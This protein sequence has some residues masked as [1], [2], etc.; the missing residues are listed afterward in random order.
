MEKTFLELVKF[1]TKEIK[2]I[3][4]KNKESLIYFEK[5]IKNS[6]FY[7]EEMYNDSIN[8]EEDYYK[9]YDKCIF[10]LNSLYNS[11]LKDKEKIFYQILKIRNE[12][13][14][15][16]LKEE[17]NSD[18][19]RFYQDK[20]NEKKEIKDWYNFFSEFNGFIKDKLNMNIDFFNYSINSNEN[21]HIKII[22]EYINENNKNDLKETI[23]D[24]KYTLCSFNFNIYT[25]ENNCDFL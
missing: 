3:N 24:D 21:I 16:F 15:I 14:K 7:M 18:S 20:Y 19:I 6:I 23:I 12:K 17:I 4:L 13:F 8:I 2:E 1:F 25:L 5:F 9:L 22:L 10:T 11:D